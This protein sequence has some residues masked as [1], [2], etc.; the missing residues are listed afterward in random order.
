M[1]AVLILFQGAPIVYL[2]TWTDY[3]L[4]RF[5]FFLLVAMVVVILNH[6]IEEQVIL[7]RFLNSL[8]KF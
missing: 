4:I 6:I 7:K 8:A 5:E 1:F 3:H 2:R